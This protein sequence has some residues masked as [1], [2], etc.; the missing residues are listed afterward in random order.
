[1]ELN[2]T[3]FA[4][5]VIL[6]IAYSH[7]NQCNPLTYTYGGHTPGPNCIVYGNCNG[8]LHWVLLESHH[9]H[10]GVGVLAAS[11]LKIAKGFAK[12]TSEVI[13][14]SG[15][16]HCTSSTRLHSTIKL[17]YHNSDRYLMHLD[18]CHNSFH[19]LHY[20]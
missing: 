16:I 7:S 17:I 14:G 2:C 10:Q 8:A 18:T 19:T 4:Y 20:D 3:H 11:S 12:T 13:L 5:V 9:Y 6:S 1:M 15:H